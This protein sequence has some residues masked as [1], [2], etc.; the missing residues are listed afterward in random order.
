MKALCRQWLHRWQRHAIRNN[1]GQYE[2]SSYRSVVIAYQNNWMSN[3]SSDGKDD[4]CSPPPIKSANSR[5][6]TNEIRTSSRLEHRSHAN[7]ENR[8]AD[9]TTLLLSLDNKLHDTSNSIDNTHHMNKYYNNDARPKSS[10]SNYHIPNRSKQLKSVISKINTCTSIEG[11]LQVVHENKQNDDQQHDLEESLSPPAWKKMSFLLSK[12]Q[13]TRNS[14][15]T[16]QELEGLYHRTIDEMDTYNPVQ[17]SNVAQSTATIV[18][19]ITNVTR[20]RQQPCC[21]EEL[22]LYNVFVNNTTFWEKILTQSLTYMDTFRPKWLVSISWAFATVLDTVNHTTNNNM[23]NDENKK[24]LLD[25]SSFFHALHETIFVKQRHHEFTSK[26]LGNIVW[27]CMACRHVDMHQLYNDC[28]NEFIKRRRKE[29][30]CNDNEKDNV[31]DGIDE[32]TLCLWSNA[33]SKVIQQ[34]PMT[35]TNHCYEELFQS[36]SDTA[37]PLLPTF[38]SRHYANLA[39]SFAVAGS[40]PK[41]EY[42][43]TDGSVVTT[44]LFD[45]IATEII[46]K[47]TSGVATF[48]SQNMA[49]ILWAYTKMNHDCPEL[50]NVIAEEAMPRIREFSPQQ[51]ANLAR[52]YSIFPSSSSLSS[53]LL[54]SDNGI[55]DCIAR[56]IVSRK[57]DNFTSQGLSML[58]N[59][60]ATVGHVTNTEFWNI[61]EED[62]SSTKRLSQLG[63]IECSQIAWSFATIGRPSDNLFHGIEKVATLKIDRIEPQGLSNLAWSFAML[64]YD[65]PDFF[66]VIAKQCLARLDDF[67]PQDKAM[68]MLA[69][70]RINHS[71][72]ELFDEIAS[73]SLPSLSDFTGLDLFNL[74]ISYV[75]VGH[76]SEPLIEAIATEIVRRRSSND[77]PPKRLVG[78]AWAYAVVGC[79]SIPL[80]NLISDECSGHINDLETNEVA[81]LA[82]SFASLN[83]HHRQFLGELAESSDG[84]WQ[85]FDAPPLANMAWAYATTGEDQ[86][87]LFEGIANAAIDKRDEFTH[88]GVAMLLW[89]FSAAGHLDRHLFDAFAPMIIQSLQEYE[90][91]SLANIAWA[92]TVA[93]V[94]AESLFGFNSPFID[95]LVKR[96][97]ELDKE[98]LCQLHQWNTWRKETT[99][100]APLPLDLEERCFHE[101]TSQTLNQSNLQKA[102]ISELV[103]MGVQLEEEAQTS[104]GY[105]LDA[106]VDVD[107]KKIG[108]EIDGPT[109]FIGR[110]PTGSTILKRRQVKVDGVPLVSVPYWEWNELKTSAE[111][112]EYL[113]YKLDTNY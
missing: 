82:W 45:E 54:E 110:R 22:V 87:R 50:F 97:D 91:K 55:F 9:E 80:F 30:Y 85:D 113:R 15:K 16:S 96:F 18:K 56:E 10:Q 106:L 78:V 14:K 65:S 38:N 24:K 109:H 26:H 29:Q 99:N 32:M 34:Q 74:L 42:N 57:M 5:L 90:A 79:R 49:N 104:S 43:T 31:V 92:Y 3:V 107:G 20:R 17:L 63:P 89:A 73:T 67:L 69:Y 21:E 46:P 27:S 111:V 47:M 35:S 102:V 52:A 72:P 58:A 23:N 11:V 101:F 100:N 83:L 76:I 41:F 98:G 33:F 28:S 93:N 105:Y 40:N 8:V 59:S 88:Q 77:F 53:S 94:D 4:Y 7:S 112:Q 103:S 70:S 95:I 48:T 64:G 60:F 44:T 81:S 19:I 75:K 1:T 71:S 36:I 62:A 51:I 12:H 37:I 108:L 66:D 39:H 2:M 86:P 6:T 68:I 13:P 61:I 84:R 25:V